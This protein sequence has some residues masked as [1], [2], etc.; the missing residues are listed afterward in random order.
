[1][2]DPMDAVVAPHAVG[3]LIHQERVG[4]LRKPSKV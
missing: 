2:H 4:P 3:S 1:L